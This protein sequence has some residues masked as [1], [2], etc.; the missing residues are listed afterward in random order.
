MCNVCGI[1]P[2]PPS[3]PPVTPDPSHAPT[4]VGCW[5][6]CDG[7]NRICASGSGLTCMNPG[8]AGGNY[9]V[10][11]ACP[12]DPNCRTDACRPPAS[13]SPGVTPPPYSACGVSGTVWTAGGYTALQP[14]NCSSN[15]YLSVPSSNGY[16]T[17]TCSSIPSG[18]I[19][20]PN[21]CGYSFV[22][23]VSPSPVTN[24]CGNLGPGQCSAQCACPAGTGQTCQ[25]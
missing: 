18:G 6:S 13:P 20:Y 3:T 25:Y 14:S 5:E 1:C 10:N 24:P 2:P 17:P 4:I 7:V 11:A 16:L 21:G 19:K 8:I 15:Q 12:A 22:P 9:C 23:T